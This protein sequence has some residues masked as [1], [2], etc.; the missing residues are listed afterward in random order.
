M[1][2]LSI[3]A[4][5]ARL[6]KT[7]PRRLG[8]MEITIA[9]DPGATFETSPTCSGSPEAAPR[10]LSSATQALVAVCTLYRAASNDAF[11]VH[12]LASRQQ[13]DWILEIT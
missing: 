3:S 5:F 4:F 8:E 1:W 12:P 11:Q 10:S 9:A 2:P 13:L 6:Q 7:S